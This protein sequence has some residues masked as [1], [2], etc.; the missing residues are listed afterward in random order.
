MAN[1]TIRN[2]SRYLAM[3][4]LE[5]VNTKGA[6]SNIVLNQTIEKHALS[7]EDSNLL[8]ELVYGVIQRKR[9]LDYTLEPL[10]DQK[11]KLENWVL[12]LLR[13]SVY[14][15]HYLERV[16][17][18]AVL[19]EAVNIAK[20]RGH[21]GI[22]GLVNGVLR[23]VL[24]SEKPDFL[25]IEDPVK[26]LGI[27]YSLPDWMIETSI[28]KIGI[29]ETEK[30]A[31]SLSEKSKVSLRVNQKQITIEEA[32]EQ[33]TAEGY[34]VKRSIVSLQGLISESGLPAKSEL[35]KSGKLTIQDESSMLVAPSLQLEPGDKV[36]DACAAPGGKTTHIASYLD[37]Q[38][39]GEVLALDLHKHKIKLI[40]E[41]AKRQNVEAVVTARNIDARKI[42]EEVQAES[43]EKILVDA[44]CSGL[45]LMRR[46]PEIRYSKTI[47]DLRSLKKIQIDILT[48]MAPLL[49][50]K[51]R[52][53][54]S[55]CTITPEE[56]EEVIQAFLEKHPDFK[57]EPVIL[58]S[59]QLKLDSDD[60]LRLYPH[61]YQTDGFF[62]CSLVKEN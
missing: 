6:F 35:F 60:M 14:Q 17:D 57:V 23:N 43:F 21:K 61:E 4:I 41:N 47:E 55:T 36:L 11:K 12:E 56:N 38:L 50:A 53:V 5:K 27:Q 20:S 49:K 42:G 25:K 28:N 34:S 18:H 22:A 58:E 48:H 30:Y 1:N 37:A 44:P 10:L 16:P 26:R 32:I 24:R 33:L 39:G 19:N 54:Y 8:T 51:G 59:N 46:K 40:E 45:G 15:L 52:L 9:T 2:S 29:E 7:R 31:Q 3:T 62:I 13:L